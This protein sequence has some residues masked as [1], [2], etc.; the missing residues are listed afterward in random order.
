MTFSFIPLR[1]RTL[2]YLG[3]YLVLQFVFASLGAEGIAWWAHIG[4]FGLGIAWAAGARQRI[5][6]HISALDAAF[7][8]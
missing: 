3:I 6:Q 1:I 2:W 8:K 4:G 7:G 5:R